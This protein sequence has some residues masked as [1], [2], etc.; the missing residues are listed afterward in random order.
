MKQAQKLLD[1]DGQPNQAAA[2]RANE[3]ARIERA[4][5]EAEIARLKPRAQVRLERGQDTAFEVI[6]LNQLTKILEDM[7]NGEQDL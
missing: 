2:W 7:N 6:R 1:K 4:A 3:L 5:I